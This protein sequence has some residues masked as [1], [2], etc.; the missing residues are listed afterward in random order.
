M[1]GSL[2]LSPIFPK[3][4]AFSNCRIQMHDRRGH[5]SFPL[6]HTNCFKI[7]QKDIFYCKTYL[8]VMSTLKK[9]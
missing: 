7:E 2:P 3:Y 9:L 4:V 8:Y 5:A 1:H 6:V